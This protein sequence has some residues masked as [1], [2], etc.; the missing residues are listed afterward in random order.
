[1]KKMEAH[2]RVSWFDGG[3][4]TLENGVLICKKCHKKGHA[5]IEVLLNG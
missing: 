5:T 4:T 2:H 3:E 1:M